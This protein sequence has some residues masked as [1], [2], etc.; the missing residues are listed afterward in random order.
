MTS[1]RGPSPV[2]SITAPDTPRRS[3]RAG[4]RA[5]SVLGVVLAVAAVVETATHHVSPWIPLAFA[6][7]PDLS[8]L[9]GLGRPALPGRLPERAVPVYNVVHRQRLPMAVV[10]VALLMD[11]SPWCLVAGLAWWAHIAADRAFGFG[12]RTKGGRQRG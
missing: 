10:M 4:R 8:F 1:H 9:A 12:L 6:V 5:W 11:L 2:P 3:T 7:G